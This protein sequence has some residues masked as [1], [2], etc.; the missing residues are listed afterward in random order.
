MRLTQITVQL[1]SYCGVALINF[2]L[3]LVSLEARFDKTDYYRLKLSS[4][5]PLGPD[6][7]QTREFAR[8]WEITI[9]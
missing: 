4:L 7:G 1:Y 6:K 9:V 3:S 2:S 5:A 8:L